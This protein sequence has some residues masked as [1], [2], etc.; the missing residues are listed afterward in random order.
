MK[1]PG[2][3][4]LK[5]VLVLVLCGCAHGFSLSAVEIEGTVV[6]PGGKPA[7]GAQVA[8]TAPGHQ[9]ELGYARLEGNLQLV[10]IADQEGHFHFSPVPYAD[11]IVAVNENGYAERGLQDYTNGSKLTLQPWG[12]IEGVL[13][14][15]TRLGTNEEVQLGAFN[16]GPAIFHN[17]SVWKTVTDGEGRFVFTCVPPG[18]RGVSHG[19]IREKFTVKPGETIHIS[20][21]GTGRAVIGKLVIPSTATNGAEPSAGILLEAP[22][23]R[24]LSVKLAPDGT[25]RVDDVPAGT[26]GLEVLISRDRINKPGA[27][28]IGAAGRTLVIP[29]M[30]GGRSDDPLDVGTVEPI[31]V[32]TPQ[33]GE[34]VPSFE[35]QTTDGGTFKLAD[36]HG[37]FVL[38]EFEPLG[39]NPET[40]F[41]RTVW[42]KFGSDHQ[43]AVLTLEVQPAGGYAIAVPH[44]ETPPWPQARLRDVPWF[45]QF[46]LRISLGLPINGDESDAG[47]SSSCMLLD[48]DGKIIAK[49]LHRDDIEAAVSKR[50][51]KK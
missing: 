43:F 1:M 24:A 28:F 11:G 5:G 33:I 51:E 45:V 32:H 48:T 30:P 12:R 27:E 8:M 22:D 41:V 4:F 18:T 35:V 37:Q 40:G 50:L 36:H 26:W 2:E 3:Q 19:G 20:V 47:T 38:L 29:E 21:G 39:A 31:I 15:G 42:K 49:N 13:R 25:F 34:T 10:V 44:E 14:I 9:L 16:S 46:P 23:Y 6:L 7:A 17:S